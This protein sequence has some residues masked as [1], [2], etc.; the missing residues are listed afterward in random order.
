VDPVTAYGYDRFGNLESKAVTFTTADN[1]SS[2]TTTTNTTT[3]TA[4]PWGNIASATTPLGRK[5]TDSYDGDNNLISSSSYATGASTP[6]LT[7]TDT[8]DARN[9]LIEQQVSDGTTTRISS[10]TYS[11]NNQQLTTTDPD[12]NTTTNTYNDLGQLTKT[13]QPSGDFTSYQYD[14]MGRQTTATSPYGPTLANGIANAPT[15]TKTTV[16]NADDT[17]A[18]VT[19]PDGNTTQSTYDH[20]GNLI[21][22]TDALGHTT[23]N[24]YTPAGL[25]LSTDDPDGVTHTTKYVYNS[26]DQLASKTDA[27]NKKWQYSYY[28][29]GSLEQTTNPD[30]QTTINQYDG[31]GNTTNVAYSAGNDNVDTTFNADDEPTQTTDASGTTGYSYNSLGQLYQTTLPSAKVVTDGWNA[32]SDETS[33]EVSGQAQATTYVYNADNQPTQL[34]DPNS[35]V[36]TFSYTPD[37]QLST[38]ALPTGQAGTTYSY[39]YSGAVGKAD[40]TN[41][42][43]GTT[44]DL[45]YGYDA[46]GNITSV[47][48]SASGGKSGTLGYDALNRLTSESWTGNQPYSASYVY[49]GAGNRTQ[50]TA[51]GTITNSIYN[52]DNELVSA[53]STDYTYNNEEEM[54]AE[55]PA[56]GSAT[57]YAYNVAGELTSVSGPSSNVSYTYDASGNRVEATTS[58]TA[59][60]WTYNGGAMLEADTTNADDSTTSE[61]YQQGP[62]GVVSTQTS[63]SVTGTT[64]Q[65]Y[66]QQDAL[67]ST[68]AVLDGSGDQT[69]H[70]QY[71]A[72]GNNLTTSA[73]NSGDIGFMGNQ[74]DSA[75]LDNFNAREY[76]STAGSFLS[77]DPVTSVGSITSTTAEEAFLNSPQLLNSYAYG[78]D[79]PLIDPDQSGMCALD[80]ASDLIYDVHNE[81][82]KVA[83]HFRSEITAYTGFADK[84]TFGVTA[85]IRNVFGLNGGLDENSIDY[86]AGEDIAGVALDIAAYT[87]CVGG[88]V[89]LCLRLNLVTAFD[90]PVSALFEHGKV[91]TQGFAEAAGW[92]A[93]GFL[94]GVA[95]SGALSAA[96]IHQVRASAQLFLFGGSAFITAVADTGEE[97]EKTD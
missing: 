24:T 14:D 82:S 95:S 86:Q 8:Y 93:L 27:L 89:I 9:N 65:A 75:N 73:L 36:S 51:N 7:T 94:G 18:A 35:N 85:G 17:V 70:Y 5:T 1:A 52:D 44:A 2:G 42:A 20:D 59:T 53:G 90:T 32:F 33:V 80:C 91:D 68:V 64:T 45:I 76:D 97:Y 13:T 4:D 16:Y 25:L 50:A 48:D 47:A 12:G 49:D 83:D 62:T 21:Q 55:T 23:K 10:S 26:N 30:S 63:N 3:Y 79:N 67:G 22:V 57:N 37:G 84:A 92:T 15:A 74:V 81:L 58:N 41:D 31:D 54:T 28:P 11:F 60:N 66:D 29:N 77:P 78:T 88:D 46:A 38:V 6:S 61:S 39:D 71:T 40:S 96:E 34:T 43:G 72:F 87:G 69:A 19:D 56:S